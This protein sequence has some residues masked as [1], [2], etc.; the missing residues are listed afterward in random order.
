M[1]EVIRS[2]AASVGSTDTAWVLAFPYWVDTRL[3]GVNAGVPVKDYAIWPDQLADTATEPRAKLFLVK[4]ED[5]AG[6]EAL[7]KLYP[8]GV[9]TTYVSQ[10]EN[11]D[12]LL[13]F[14]PPQTPNP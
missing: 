7:R 3:V 10:V 6:L 5:T 1:G 13:Y 4:P 12:F 9:S 11:H 14:V 2:F 8:L